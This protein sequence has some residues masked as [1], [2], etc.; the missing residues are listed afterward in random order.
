MRGKLIDQ[1][2]ARLDEF[3]QGILAFERFALPELH[4]N[5]GRSCTLKLITPRTKVQLARLFVHGIAFPAQ[6]SETHG[7]VRPVQR[8]QCFQIAI[9]LHRYDV[10]SAAESNHIA[11]IDDE[12]IQVGMA[13][14]VSSA[15]KEYC[16]AKR[17]EAQCR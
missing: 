5:H 8:Q 9:A 6:V 10:L 12:A 14:R 7:L 3:R 15:V 16:K 4:E 2:V 13:R 1:L 17:K 11:A